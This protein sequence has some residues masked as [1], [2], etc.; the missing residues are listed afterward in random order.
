MVRPS[1][2]GL[3]LK[4]ATPGERQMR[5]AYELNGFSF[6]II[7]K[8]GKEQVQLDALSR[9]EQDIPCD[10]DDDRIANRHHQLLKGDTES[11]KVVAKAT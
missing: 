10:V 1:Q 7:H 11:L 5:W 3:F 4:E 9:R 2:F 6:D 8:P